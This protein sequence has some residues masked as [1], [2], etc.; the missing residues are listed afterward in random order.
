VAAGPEF[1]HQRRCRRAPGVPGAILRE[2]GR[3]SFP[4]GNGLAPTD[5]GD[6]I[7]LNHEF[8]RCFHLHITVR[9]K[10]G[11]AD[12]SARTNCCGSCR[13]FTMDFGAIDLK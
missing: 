3:W 1:L 11:N 2:I 5:P 9:S 4:A 10:K 13:S 12:R 7:V 6:I 8:Y